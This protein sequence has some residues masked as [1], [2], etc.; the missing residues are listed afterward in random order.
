M[1]I[2]N[3]T[4][5]TATDDQLVAGV[6][7]PSLNFKNII[8]KYLSFEDIPSKDDLN[9][10][11][12]ALTEIALTEGT[13]AVMIGGAPFFMSALEN[14]LK[15]EGIRV[16]YAFSKRESV[17]VTAEDG[18]VSKTSVFRHAGFVEI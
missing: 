8:K 4:Q 15:K 16:F 1:Q 9:R 18:S 5:H 3:L 6:V 7:E 11:A 13:S 14:A 2:L 10:C 17:E 12:K